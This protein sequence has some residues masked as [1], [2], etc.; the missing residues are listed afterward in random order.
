MTL[1]SNH[2]SHKH[3]HYRT[4]SV[5]SSQ[6]FTN[7]PKECS[8]QGSYVSGNYGNY[9]GQKQYSAKSYQEVSQ[10]TST[11]EDGLAHKL[12]FQQESPVSTPSSGYNG[13]LNFTMGSQD[14]SMSTT[15]SGRHPLARYI[16]LYSI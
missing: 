3:S 6:D 2:Y 13:H 7:R 4:D 12:E 14:N 1:D 10:H 9:N 16:K 5:L 15:S 11:H 8:F